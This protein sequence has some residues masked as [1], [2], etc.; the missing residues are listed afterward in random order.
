MSGPRRPSTLSRLLT[1]GAWNAL[2][3]VVAGA[4]AFLMVPLLLQHLGRDSYGVWVLIGSLFAYASILHFGLSSAIN[5]HVPVALAKGDEDAVRRVLTTGSVFFAGV[6]AVV[7]VATVLLRLYFVAWFNVPEALAP[8]VER[9]VLVVG[10][11]LALTVALQAF[12]AALSGYQRYDLS[13]IS[14]IVFLLVR[15]AVLWALVRAG[16]GLLTVAWTFGLTELGVNVLQ[17]LLGMRLMPTRPLAPRWFEPRLLREMLAYGGNTFLYSTGAVI[18]YKASE[19]V[20]G[21]MRRPEDVASYAVAATGVLT[22]S[23]VV[24]SL[25]AAIKPAVSDLDA[26]DEADAIRRLALAAQKFALLVI[27]PSTAFLVLMGGDFLR[28]WTGSELRE[29]SVAMALL[30]VGQAFRLAQQSNFL[31]LVGKGEH[32]FFGLAVLGVGALTIA[33]TLI[34]VGPL[35]LGV[36]GAAG[37]S[38]IA[39][40]VIAGIVIPRHVDRQFGVTRG[41]RWG[42]VIGPA[43]LGSAPGIALMGLWTAVRPLGSWL[44]VAV[45]TASVAAATAASAWR[46]SLE[47]AE[48]TRLAGLLGRVSRRGR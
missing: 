47:P 28:L 10:G 20:V 18:A 12:G 24:E 27:L 1:N 9:A 30:A 39:W 11:M 17:M 19:V 43:V 32:R 33:L 35:D 7:L 6:G 48:R 25:S 38:C 37:A 5:R 41:E 13:A 21:V 40:A 8:E 31:V 26:R 2:S 4:I 46:F 34:G 45:V 16:A 22:L 36:I 44:E 23:A 29:V 3:T 14:R 42:R 15:G